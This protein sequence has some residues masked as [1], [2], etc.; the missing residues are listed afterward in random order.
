VDDLD[1]AA[2]RAG[3]AP[4]DSRR[5]LYLCA[6]AGDTTGPPPRSKLTLR[7][8]KERSRPRAQARRGGGNGR[9]ACSLCAHLRPRASRWAGC[10]PGAAQVLRRLERP[11]SGKQ[12]VE[13]PP[14]PAGP[15]PRPHSPRARAPPDQRPRL[16][17]VD[18]TRPRLA[19][20]RGPRPTAVETQPN[21]WCERHSGRADTQL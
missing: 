13:F 1:P 12:G 2:R 18:K 15:T 17:W 4:C 10:D 3:S 7:V 21:V 8:G 19:Q 20:R 11:L 5:P 16:C 9:C 6:H 14:W